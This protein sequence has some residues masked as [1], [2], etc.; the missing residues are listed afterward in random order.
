MKI[1]FI[2][3]MPAAGVFPEEFIRFKYRGNSH[4]APWIVALLPALAKVSGF[5]LR[6]I[7]IQHAILRHCLVEV[8][9]VE[10]EGIPYWLPERFNFRLLQIPKSIQARLALKRYGPD[11]VHAFGMETGAAMIALRSGFPVSCFIQGISEKYHLYYSRRPF[12]DVTAERWSEARAV[13]R[14]RWFVGETEFAQK[15]A[16]GWNPHAR[17]ALI[18]HPLRP[19]FLLNAAPTYEPQI[20]S[21]GGLDRRK[22]IDTII[23]AFAKTKTSNSRLCIVGSG[24]LDA[25]LKELSR[26]LGIS[27]RVEFTGALN[28]ES[29]IQRM[30]ASC[31]FVIA[32]RVDTSP[33][34]LSEAHAIG[35]P[36]IGTQGGGIPEMIDEGVDG[37]I[38]GIEDFATMG[39]RM[40][41]L[42]SD[43]DTCRKMGEAGREKVKLLN[44]PEIVAQ[45]HLDF[46]KSIQT[47]LSGEIR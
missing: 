9:G 22:G 38:V 28:T 41:Q 30:N 44:A 25:E 37:Y 16:L 3:S 35:L 6:V 14:I 13:R 43:P 4:P 32:S 21:V 5:K 18:P 15:W 8:D 27:D 19:E 47:E 10:Y 24:P 17:V 31:A 36:V 39:L 7:L 34:V 45:A 33:N 1:A 23:K 40:D 20:L 12:G 42:L 2:G 46:F 29:V 26:K 11:V